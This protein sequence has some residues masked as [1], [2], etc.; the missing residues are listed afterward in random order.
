MRIVGLINGRNTAMGLKPTKHRT[1]AT[2]LSQLPIGEDS[3]GLI[4]AGLM[5]S[6]QIAANHQLS[7]IMN[8]RGD[9]T[10][11]RPLP[12]RSR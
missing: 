4:L 8:R 9:A 3:G 10:R 6:G 7:I 11:Q 12:S 1:V 2:M 5:S